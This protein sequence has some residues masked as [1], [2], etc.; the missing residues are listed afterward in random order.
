MQKFIGRDSIGYRHINAYYSNPC[1]P[2][3]SMRFCRFLNDL[4]QLDP[5]IS[6]LCLWYLASWQPVVIP[7]VCLFD[8][9][10]WT[11]DTLIA[12]EILHLQAWL[13]IFDF[14]CS[15]KFVII[16]VSDC[17]LPTHHKSPNV[18][19]LL[20]FPRCS[21]MSFTWLVYNQK[22]GPSVQPRG[23]LA[24]CHRDANC[25][26]LVALMAGES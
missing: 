9:G 25:A 1:K 11:N 21:S 20:H 23:S 26:R 7:V 13:Q 8:P 4:Q 2:G 10:P 14:G 16:L 24:S 3:T 5:N 6:K 15:L 19:I 17:G 12:V 18:C 22:A